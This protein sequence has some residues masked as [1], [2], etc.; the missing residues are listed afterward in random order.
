MNHA[1]TP[2]QEIASHQDWVRDLAQSLVGDPFLAEDLA[3]ESLAAA[4]KNPPDASKPTRPW[5][6]RVVRNHISQ[7][8]RGEFRRRRREKL[9]REQEVPEPAECLDRAAIKQ[10]LHKA[11]ADMAEP[12][13]STIRALF[14]DGL[15]GTEVAKQQGIPVQTVY[16]RRERGLEQLRSRLDAQYGG[17]RLA[18]IAAFAPFLQGIGAA[19][20][21]TGA[22]LTKIGGGLG[23]WVAALFLAALGGWAVWQAFFA[24]ADPAQADLVAQNSPAFSAPAQSNTQ[25]EPNPEPVEV[26]NANEGREPFEQAATPRGEQQEGNKGQ[27]PPLTRLRVEIRDVQG[28][29]IEGAK[30]EPVFTFDGEAHT[31]VRGVAELILKPVRG[32]VDPKKNT[33]IRIL[34]RGYRL[35]YEEATVVQEK[36]VDMGSFTLEYG[37]EV[38]GRVTDAAGAPVKGAWIVGDFEGRMKLLRHRFYS[39]HDSPPLWKAV[40]RSRKDGS[41]VLSGLPLGKLSLLASYD[42]GFQQAWSA[43]YAVQRQV[44]VYDVVLQLRAVPGENLITGRVMNPEGEPIQ[45]VTIEHRSQE[46]VAYA[47]PD[48]LGE[49]RIMTSGPNRIAQD[50]V[51]FDH[52]RKYQEK[53]VAKVAP[54]TT[55]LQIYMQPARKVSVQVTGAESKPLLVP[56]RMRLLVEDNFD[57][58]V[59]ED[60]WSREEIVQNTAD[61]A[62]PGRPFVMEILAEGLQLHRSGPHDPN[63]FPSEQTVSLE[64]IP[65]VQGRVVANGTLMAGVKI[66]LYPFYAGEKRLML[67]MIYLSRVH[68]DAVASAESDEEGRFFLSLRKTG[69]YLIRA[70]HP[71]YA[72]TEWGP[73]DLDAGKGVQDLE[74]PLTYGGVLEGRLE[75]RPGM[76]VH[77][78]IVAFSRG[79]AWPRTTRIE[80]DGSFRFDLVP[81][82]ACRVEL[83]Q[84]ERASG[85]RSWGEIDG[86]WDWKP[87]SEVVDGQST[88]FLLTADSPRSGVIRSKGDVPAELLTD[89]LEESAEQQDSDQ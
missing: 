2:P 84:S 34:K 53:V 63:S 9:W 58:G 74:I 4:M 77:K 85:N 37:G 18:W 8:W 81:P 28:Q 86:H 7:Y 56:W 21:I 40:T 25:T 60:A 54:G 26:W 49:F 59:Y 51:L 41:F 19:A 29:P 55:D 76:D 14:L 36:T 75:L 79:Y 73:L 69:T 10:L 45:D 50:L 3:Q 80:A 13:Q 57:P 66:N 52:A 1:S 68:K 61:F 87:N 12:Y 72:P 20:P 78:Q 62:I 88:W 15:K 46:L 71:E 43:V 64:T 82:G 24:N 23:K 89:V 70:V 42:E 32:P 47:Y 22:P 6:Y 11:L 83:V 65:G 17:D 27:A 33:S 31:D 5:L 16:K 67:D 30:V 48:D 39:Q 35:R 44:P 38:H